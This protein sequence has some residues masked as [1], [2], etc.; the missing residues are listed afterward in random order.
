M[1]G[2]R[3]I[4]RLS[5]IAKALLSLAGPGRWA[6]PGP[7]PGGSRRP[8]RILHHFFDFAGQNRFHIHSSAAVGI[9]AAEF[10]Y[11][12]KKQAA[13]RGTFQLVEGDLTCYVAWQERRAWWRDRAWQA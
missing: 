9:P 3:T 11:L 13:R 4:T 2:L 8:V 5:F 10:D 1:P 12:E 7:R 6:A